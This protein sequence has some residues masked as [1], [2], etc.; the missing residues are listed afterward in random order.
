MSRVLVS[1]LT[2]LRR[3]FLVFERRLTRSTR[4]RNDRMGLIYQADLSIFLVFGFWGFRE[5][6]LI[7]VF[8]L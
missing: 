2:R 5:K 7:S 8:V 1:L 6:G 4:N 3:M